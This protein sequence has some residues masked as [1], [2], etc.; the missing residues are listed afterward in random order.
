MKGYKYGILLFSVFSY[1]T[2][3][4]RK[5]LIIIIL[6]KLIAITFLQQLY[7]QQTV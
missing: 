4:H 7:V 1:C 5:T 3:E 2:T 6:K